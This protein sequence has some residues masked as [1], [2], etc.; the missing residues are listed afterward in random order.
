MPWYDPCSIACIPDNHRPLPGETEITELFA[1]F[2]RRFVVVGGGTTGYMAAAMLGRQLIPHG[3]EVVVVAPAEETGLGV[4]E[5]TIPS[6]H[7][8]LDHLGQDEP[9]MMRACHATYKLGIQFVDW[10]RPERQYWHPFGVCGAL[11]DGRDLF[12]Y[13]L[14]ASLRQEARRPYQA[15]SLQWAAAL[16]GK[17]PQG[18][19]GQSP[20]AATRA[21]AFHIDATAFAAW[22]RSVAVAAGVRFIDGR[23]TGATR[24]Q[25]ANRI[26]R[27][28]LEDGQD[29]TGDFFL[30][31]TGFRSTLLT[32][33]LRAPFIDWGGQLL[34]DRAIA[35]RLP[36][37]REIPPFTRSAALSA[38]WAWTIPLQDR[39][40]WGYVYDSSYLSDEDAA[41]ELMKAAKS[42]G[43]EPD[44]PP[45]EPTRIRLRVGRQ[46]EPWVGNV[47]AVGLAAGFVEPLESTAL[48]LT[49]VG[50][51][52]FLELLPDSR[53]EAVCRDIYNRT[54]T[55][56]LDE[57]RDFVQ[58]HYHLSERE[59]SEFW[60]A[61][62]RAPISATLESK[63]AGYDACG[64]LGDLLPEAFPETSYYFLLSGNQRLPARPS[65]LAALA[66]PARLQEA[67][68][69]ILAQNERACRELPLHEEVL[70]WVHGGAPLG[71]G[72][73][74]GGG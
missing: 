55:R 10:Y 23:V 24:G 61:A 25:D 73:Q 52:R 16:S 58:L 4:G 41:A 40:G 31:C 47:L 14:A 1:G 43:F 45:P 56:A 63:L 44:G 29:V 2:P 11:I 71:P 26:E 13:W 38:G 20:I 6:L 27:L 48:H 28:N 9:S 7:R 33:C 5:A 62:R 57:V 12:P 65:G 37:R 22:L 3:F 36:G 68:K 42:Q 19:G 72:P 35:I 67:L 59:D 30:D 60:Q 51:E 15:F 39:V 70:D 69:Q 21:Y 53:S 18:F 49:Q 32:E 54:L 66:P 8:L 64:W 17:S 50:L 46:A 74:P 34:C